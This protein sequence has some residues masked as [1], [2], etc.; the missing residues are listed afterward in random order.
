MPFWNFVAA[1]KMQIDNLVYQFAVFR[2]QPIIDSPRI[3]I[4]AQRRLIDCIGLIFEHVFRTQHFLF[5]RFFLIRQ[6]H[7]QILVSHSQERMIGRRR[8]GF[9]N[10]CKSE[11]KD[12][13]KRHQR[14]LRRH[15]ILDSVERI[16]YCIVGL[17]LYLCSKCLFTTISNCSD[18][19]VR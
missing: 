9:D 4:F 18:S 7:S 16:M 11:R 3:I 6:I 12:E 5:D 2:R 19:A 10:R 1:S 15:F 17:C 13:K 14:R 8:A